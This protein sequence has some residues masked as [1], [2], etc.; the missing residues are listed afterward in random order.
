MRTL[1]TGARAPTCLDLA[2]RFHA[3]GHTVF[4]ADGLRFGTAMFSRAARGHFKLPRANTSPEAYVAALRSL[5]ELHRIDLLI[6]TCEEVFVLS[7]YRDHLGCDV[8]VDD[9]E[10]LSIIHNKFRFS[11]I[12]GNSFAATPET[13]QVIRKDQWQPFENDPENWVFKPVFSRFAART[14]IGPRQLELKKIVPSPADPWVVQRRIRGQEY[15]TYSI[16]HEGKLLAHACYK[17]LYRAGKGAGICFE[18]TNH[19]GIEGFVREFVMSQ[20]FTGQIGF[21]LLEQFDGAVFV[22]EANPRST[23]GVHLFA[24]TRELTDCF[25]GKNEAL[26]RPTP[27]SPMMV[28]FAMPIWG[29]ADAVRRG[30]VKR[31]LADLLRARWT[32]FCIRDPLPTLALPLS[33]MELIWIA[34]TEKR[35][36]LEA[37]TFDIE[38][39]GGPL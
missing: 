21:D 3:A 23:S 14:L 33:L 34:V 7:R 36:L 9:F 25:M 11:Q 20:K 31:F 5:V 13:H 16:A 37:S 39:N 28:E 12:A 17:S 32:S 1:L 22:I 38:W 15:S 10:K 4:V 35:G 2:R 6:P 29:L 24:Q 8:F 30:C 26:I 27:M 18:P 19:S